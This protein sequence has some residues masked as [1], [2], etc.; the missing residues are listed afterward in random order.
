MSKRRYDTRVMQVP[1]MAE[2]LNER[3]I[4]SSGANLDSPEASLLYSTTPRPIQDNL[5]QGNEFTRPGI[6]LPRFD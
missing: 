6:K 3:N 2:I 5:K 4:V 1:K